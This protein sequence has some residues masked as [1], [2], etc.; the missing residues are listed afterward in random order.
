[1]IL[2]KLDKIKVLDTSATGCYNPGAIFEARLRAIF[3]ALSK[4][5]TTFSKG[6]LK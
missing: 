6:V 5:M 4:F 3:I 1:M 2:K